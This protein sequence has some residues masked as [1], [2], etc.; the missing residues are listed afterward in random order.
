[1]QSSLGFASFVATDS[2]TSFLGQWG[3][4][5]KGQRAGSPVGYADDRQG[6]LLSLLAGMPGPESDRCLLYILYIYIYI[7]LFP[8]KG[9]MFLIN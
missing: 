9:T 3:A 5:G 8:S 6:M 2:T 1:M 4:G 7:Y